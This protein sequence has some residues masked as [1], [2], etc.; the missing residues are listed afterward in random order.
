MCNR[1]DHAHATSIAATPSGAM[2][3]KQGERHRRAGRHPQVVTHRDWT[4]RSR[5]EDMGGREGLDLRRRQVA[6]KAT[7]HVPEA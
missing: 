2:A 4:R 3:P 6:S 7:G 1:N 5:V